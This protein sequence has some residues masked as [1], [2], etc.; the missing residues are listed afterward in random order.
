VVE[1][2][3]PYALAVYE[4]GPNLMSYAV[5]D[6][7]RCVQLYAECEASGNW[8]SYPTDPQVIDINAAPT[9]ANPITFA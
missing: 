4:I 2:T 1:K 9:A 8:P 7:E 6:F 5:E 3:P